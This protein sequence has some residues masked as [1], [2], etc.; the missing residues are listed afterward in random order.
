MFNGIYPL[1]NK[2]IDRQI[3]FNTNSQFFIDYYKQQFDEN[4]GKKSILYTY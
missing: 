2:M 4:I 1:T 3:V